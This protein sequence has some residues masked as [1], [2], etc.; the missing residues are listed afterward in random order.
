[1]KI[2]NK[3]SIVLSGEELKHL[4]SVA[5]KE[6]LTPHGYLKKIVHSDLKLQVEYKNDSKEELRSHLQISLS[7]EENKKLTLISKNEGVKK[8]ILVKNIIVQSINFD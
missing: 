8:E 2:K 5:R 7:K 6:C 3:V 1:M 4:K